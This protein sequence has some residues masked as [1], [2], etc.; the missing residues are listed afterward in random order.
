MG[1]R[2][3][4]IVDSRTSSSLFVIARTDALALEGLQVALERAQ[5]YVECGA[6]AIFPEAVKSLDEYREFVL[7]CKVPVLANLTEFGQTPLFSL[8]E[9]GSVGVRMALYPLTAFR[10]MSKSALAVY[11]TLRARGTQSE[12]LPLMQT[13][14]ELYEVI[15]YHES[16][17]YLDEL[18]AQ[19]TK[20]EAS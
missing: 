16:E 2:L 17:N 13:R 7:R 1:S 6:D 10:V 8:G 18:S 5:F 11:E 12:L 19:K 14:S 15:K 20:I 4:A 3:K 9:L